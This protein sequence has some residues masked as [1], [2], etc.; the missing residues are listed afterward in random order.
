MQ[1]STIHLKSLIFLLPVI[2]ASYSID[3]HLIKSLQ[4]LKNVRSLLFLTCETTPHPLMDPIKTLQSD[5]TWIN[6]LDISN[7]TVISE[8]IFE[9][10]FL[11][12]NCNIMVVCSLT[13][14]QSRKFLTEISKLKKFHGERSWLMFS[15]SLER[16]VDVL[17][18]QNINSDAEITLILPSKQT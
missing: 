14:Y 13:C 11:R 18:G 6:T 3:F 10:F 9:Q 16:S 7:Q 2:V 12:L 4:R 8:L 15:D 5:D 17:T 1:H